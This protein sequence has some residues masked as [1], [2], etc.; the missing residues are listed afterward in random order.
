[1]TPILFS[2]RS[3][4]EWILVVAGVR[5]LK[6]TATIE[7]SLRDGFACV[8]AAALPSYS[9]VLSANARWILPTNLKFHH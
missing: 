2:R 1:M 9:R 3:A 4:T 6:P 8:V 7:A 5:G